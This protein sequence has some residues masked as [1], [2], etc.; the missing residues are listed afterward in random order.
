MPDLDKALADILVIRNHIAAGAAF[1]G[2]GPTALAATGVL[3]IGT[4]ALQAVWLDDANAEPLV[5]LA[6][7]VATAIFAAAIIG[8]E[9]L[10][11]SRRLHS[12][13]AGAM[14]YN[15]I[16]QFLPAGA[17]GACLA[18]VLVRFAPVALWMLTGLWQI[19]VSLGIFASVRSLP[20]AVGFAG[21]WYFVAGLGVLMFASQDHTLSPWMMGAPFAIGQLLIAAILHFAFGAEDDQD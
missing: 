3:A 1:R 18:A 17:A 13:L 9:M 7:W 2:Y 19:L 6:G 5:F 11:R 14:I 8:V 4:A 20:G 21:A 12:R 15:A 16:E 10:G